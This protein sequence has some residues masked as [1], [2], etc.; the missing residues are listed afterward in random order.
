MS[1]LPCTYKIFRAAAA[2]EVNET[3]AS[4]STPPA[5][6]ITSGLMLT[7]P[8]TR[9]RC[10]TPIMIYVVDRRSRGLRRSRLEIPNAASLARVVRRDQIPGVVLRGS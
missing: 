1:I 10:A 4:P 2:S 9:A 8:A 6:A 7:E 5:N 3:A